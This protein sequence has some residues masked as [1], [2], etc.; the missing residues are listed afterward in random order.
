MPNDKRIAVLTMVRN[1]NFFLSKWVEYYSGQFGR[2]N[3]Y[4]WFDGKDQLVPAFCEGVNTETV[5]HIEGNVRAADKGRIDFLSEKAVFLFGRYDMVIGTDVDEFLVVDPSTG[6]SLKEFLS[7]KSCRTALNSISGLGVD[8]GQHLEKEF[9]I[10]ES[11]PFLRQRHYA[12]LSTRYSK[13]S[14]L[15]SPVPWGSGFHRT[16]KGNFHIVKDL[17][18]FHFGCV[19][20]GCIEEKMKDKD[21]TEAGWSRHLRKRAETIY[22]VSKK[23]ALSWERT[24]PVVRRLQNTV[25]PPYCWNKPAMFEAKVVIEIPE[26][27]GG[28]V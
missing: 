28:I 2:E 3:L 19:D 22:L 27:F 20:L 18:L 9:P 4:V 13:T 17:Y 11:V 23:K 15:L 21:L 8:V 6:K 14:V 25:R 1:D 7:E 12:K 10:K 16:R 5:P 24:V 26:R